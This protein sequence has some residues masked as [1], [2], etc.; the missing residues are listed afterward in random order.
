MVDGGGCV[1][2]GRRRRI[3]NHGNIRGDRERAMRCCGLGVVVLAVAATLVLAVPRAQ[4]STVWSGWEYLGGQLAGKPAVSAWSGHVDVFVRGTDQGLYHQVLGSGA[5]E[6]LGGVLGPPGTAGQPGWD[7]AAVSWA[8]GRIDVFVVGAD[9]ALWHRWSINGAWSG[10]ESRGGQLTAS[11]AVAS[12]APGRLDVFG[13]GTDGQL[14]HQF[15]DGA[16]WSSWERLGGAFT[17]G[18]AAASWAP[19]RIDLFVRGTDNVL[20]HRFFAAAWSGWEGLGG[21]LTSDP[22]A[23]AWGSARLDVFVR[24]TDD[25]V[26]Q[27]TF[28]GA[29]SGFTQIPGGVLSEAPGVAANF[30]R[31]ELFARGTDDALYHRTGAPPPSSGFDPF[32]GLGSWADVYDWSVTHGGNPPPFTLADVDHMADEGVQ[33][34]YIQPVAWTDFA[35]ILELDR[36]HGIIDRAHQRGLQVVGWYLPDLRNVANDLR[37]LIAVASLGVDGV[38]VDIESATVSDPVARSMLLVSLSDQLRARLPSSV[39]SAIVPAPVAMDDIVPD[40]WPGFP[41][42]RLAVDYD[43][44]QPM[45]YVTYRTGPLRDAYTYFAENITR[46]RSHVG[47]PTAIVGPIGGIANGITTDDVAGMV[48]ACAD[49]G[50]I[51]SGLYDYLT[52]DD[53]LWPA[54]RSL[55][56][57]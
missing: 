33:T 34:L 49:L 3:A 23:S 6:A 41:W 40:Y 27:Q 11:P 19:G 17:G 13:R 39:L 54:L 25:T 50:C 26:Y 9:G 14:Y 7:P 2:C 47:Q 22:A 42:D 55:R 20:Y 38:A 35:D 56:S 28:A 4:A 48:R 31:I 37:H 5:Y 15:Y 8:P 29:W 46:L 12:W 43:V 44:W 32:R 21:V 18:P 10:W 57:G 51:G 16:A 24:G 53:S 45:A 52:T 36:V 1:M 30:N